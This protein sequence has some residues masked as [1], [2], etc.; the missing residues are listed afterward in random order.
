MYPYKYAVFILLSTM[1]CFK[2]RKDYS[3][4]FGRTDYRGKRG[5]GE[6][7]LEDAADGDEG[8]ST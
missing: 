1:I 7:F 6:N 3:A 2:K 4:V 8:G 5:N